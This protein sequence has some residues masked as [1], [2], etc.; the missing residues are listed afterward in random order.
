MKIHHRDDE[1]TIGGSLVSS[2][3]TARKYAAPAA[4]FKINKGFEMANDR[5]YGVH[6]RKA[7]LQNVCGRI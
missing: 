2:V 4:A 3:V 7:G 6:S 5:R 1:A